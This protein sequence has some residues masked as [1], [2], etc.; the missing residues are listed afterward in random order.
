MNCLFFLGIL[1]WTFF[2]TVVKP[3][4]IREKKSNLLVRSYLSFNIGSLRFKTFISRRGEHSKRRRIKA[5]FRLRKQ[6]R[7]FGVRVDFSSC[8]PLVMSCLV[9]ASHAPDVVVLFNQRQHLSREWKN[10]DVTTSITPPRAVSN[11]YAPFVLHAFVYRYTAILVCWV[12]HCV[13]KAVVIK[14]IQ[15]WKR[16][17][18]HTDNQHFKSAIS[19]AKNL[20]ALR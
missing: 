13:P 2:I 20:R 7:L 10:S 19:L 6:E 18:G 16:A 14:T 15:R 12:H 8:H 17:D 4:R 1:R 9:I 11:S 3:G 5:H